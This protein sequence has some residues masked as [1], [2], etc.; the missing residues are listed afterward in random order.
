[1]GGRSDL[2][3]ASTESPANNRRN[4]KD[5]P[6]PE[7]RFSYAGNGGTSLSH[8]VTADHFAEAFVRKDD[9]LKSIKGEYAKESMEMFRDNVWQPVPD[10]AYKLMPV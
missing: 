1:L 5:S 8:G 10:S 2:K 7:F 3:V 6:M 9:Y 4:V